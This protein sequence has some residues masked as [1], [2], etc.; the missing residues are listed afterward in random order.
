MAN[1][2]GI[3]QIFMRTRRL[4]KGEKMGN[5]VV[6]PWGPNELRDA[7]QSLVGPSRVFVDGFFTLN[8]RTTDRD[9]MPKRYAAVVN[10]SEALR[11]VSDRIPLLGDA[12]DSLYVQASNRKA[13]QPSS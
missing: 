4:V 9:L 2:Y 13:F 5:F 3:R 10:I 7:F 1:K 6:R 11:Q 12:A 8:P